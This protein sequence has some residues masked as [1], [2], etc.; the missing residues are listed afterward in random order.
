MSDKT[1]AETVSQ[2][3]SYWGL[4]S[5][6]WLAVYLNQVRKGT[7]FSIIMLCINIFLAG[8]IGWLSWEL[9]PDNDYKNS[10]VSISWFLAY[11]LLDLLEQ[12]GVSLFIE[13]ILW[14]K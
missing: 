12:R 9:L 2:I 5:L 11:P 7:K 4:G 10:L 8:W 13:K 14:K 6:G 3:V 1:I